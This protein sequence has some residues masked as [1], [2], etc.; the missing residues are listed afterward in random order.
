[1][2]VIDFEIPIPY[3]LK[4]CVKLYY[5]WV[6]FSL[7][8]HEASLNETFCNVTRFTS[9]LTRGTIFVTSCLLPWMTNP[10]ENE[11]FS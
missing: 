3:A 1:M 11:V 9:R 6:T 2:K 4:F 10:F 7:Y 5:F 8:L